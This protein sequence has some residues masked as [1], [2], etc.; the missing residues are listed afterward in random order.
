[1]LLKYNLA[2]YRR[3]VGGIGSGEKDAQGFEAVGHGLFLF[4]EF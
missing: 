2:M 4:E 3:N 1:V